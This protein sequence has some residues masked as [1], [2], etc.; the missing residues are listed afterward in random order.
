M[1]VIL[2]ERGLWRDKLLAQ[3]KDFKCKE[4]A[5]NCCSP[6]SHLEEVIT[7]RGHECDF[8]PKFHCELNFIEQYW[9]AAKLRY[10]LTPRTQSFEAM[11]KNIVACLDDVPPLQIHRYANRSAR[12]MDAYAKGLSGS[13]AAWATKRYHGHRVLPNTIMEELEKAGKA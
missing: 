4:G 10:R 7:A 8:Y 11:Q 6:K 5:T 12:F 3:C 2:R 13:Q 1:E 9:G